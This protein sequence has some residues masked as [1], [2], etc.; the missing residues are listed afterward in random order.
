MNKLKMVPAW[1]SLVVLAAHFYRAGL[2]V[3]TVILVFLPFFWIVRNGRVIRFT[4]GVLLLG[5]FEWL[6]TLVVLVEY[7]N[8]INQPWGRMALILGLVAVVGGVSIFLLNTVLNTYQKGKEKR[9]L[10]GG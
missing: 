7:R 2:V 6:R 1:L 3:L 4:Q 5:V 9:S 8:S 10:L